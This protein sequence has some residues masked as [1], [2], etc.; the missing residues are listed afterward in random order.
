VIGRRKFIYD[1]WGDA[2]NMASRMESSGLADVIQTT[3]ATFALLKQEYDFEARSDV[4]VKG[5]GRVTTYLLMGRRTP[6]LTA[7]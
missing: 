6:K 2:V 1:I 3:D 5:K 7:G 4:D